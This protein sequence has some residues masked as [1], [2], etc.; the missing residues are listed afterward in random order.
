[1]QAT[2]VRH[3]DVL[4]SAPGRVEHDAE[5]VW[6][7]EAA[8]AIA[9]VS[10]GATPSAV[11]LSGCGPCVVPVAR[12]GSALRP[13][14]LYGADTRA[15]A[16]VAALGAR[17]PDAAER[18]GMPFTS[19]SLIPKLDWIAEHEPQVADRAAAYLTTTGFLAQRLTRELVTDHHQAGYLAPAYTDGTWCDDRTGTHLVWSDQV[20][21]AVT[22]ASAEHAGLAAGTPVVAG[23][24][25]GL[26]DLVGAG[27]PVANYGSTLTVGALTESRAGGE[28]LW[29]TPGARPRER[30]VGGGLS[31]SGA[32]TTW[33]RDE[34]AAG[35]D[36]DTLL[37]EA[38]HSP[39]GAGGVLAVPHLAGER[40]PVADPAARG[41][42]VGLSLSSTRGDLYRS[43]LE[44]T[45]YAL[46]RLLQAFAEAGVQPRT[47]RAV[48]GGTR[49]RLWPQLVADVT[50]VPQ[51][52]VGRHHGA[53]YGAAR[54]AAEGVGLLRSGDPSWAVVTE[55]LHPDPDGT[56]FHDR[57]YPVFLDLQE[58]LRDLRIPS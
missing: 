21:G 52:L 1:M 57:A 17:H 19:Q 37:A 32:V 29:R 3:H 43:V 48:G 22:P 25:D 24:S 45:A 30:M 39:R 26:T 8:D 31:A 2:A 5:A 12:D 38:E 46:R 16:Q 10:A 20:V 53:A 51:E 9:E 28:G 4:L 50:G 41:A 54:L 35:A 6:W 56:A 42:F 7:H 47:L 44:G 55:T 34:L 13:G 18:F 23:S 40:T 49:G 58:R 11:G 36:L 27:G 15:S 14:I 33:F